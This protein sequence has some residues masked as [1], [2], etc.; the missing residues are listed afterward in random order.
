MNVRYQRMPS[1]SEHEEGDH[2]GDVLPID[3]S[4]FETKLLS[5]DLVLIG[6]SKE[7]CHGD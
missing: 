6:Q 2:I 4:V 7:H 5:R 1:I 3:K